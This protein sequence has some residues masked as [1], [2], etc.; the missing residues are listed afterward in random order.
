MKKINRRKS[1]PDKEEFI[2]YYYS[3]SRDELKSIL[4]ISDD[5]VRRCIEEF[6]LELRCPYYSTSRKKK[7][8]SREDLYNYYIT[9]NHSNKETQKYFNL[10]SSSLTRLLREYEIDKRYEMDGRRKAEVDINLLYQYYIVENH[11]YGDTIKKFNIGHRL[12]YSL[13]KEYPELVKPKNLMLENVEKEI[14]NRY[15]K[16]GFPISNAE[17]RCVD[18]LKQ[19]YGDDK[20]IQQYKDIVRYPFKC[21]I[22]LVDFDLFIECNFN[23]THGPHPFDSNNKDD[24]DLLSMWRSKTSGDDYWSDAIEV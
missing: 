1:L 9:E 24:V 22:Y 17:Q 12:F 16:L 19:L 18:K 5:M 2:K 13:S 10:G 6:N 4:G 23:W 11:T 7:Y 8:V 20:V 15:G 14:L 3:V 21:D